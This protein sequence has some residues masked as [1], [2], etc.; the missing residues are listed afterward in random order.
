MRNPYF[1]TFPGLSLHYLKII[2]LTIVFNC[3]K[4]P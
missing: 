3:C 4:S 1:P 2:F